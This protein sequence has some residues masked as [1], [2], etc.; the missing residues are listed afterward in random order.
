MGR[1]VW[2][3]DR[4]R[5]PCGLLPATV[6][7]DLEVHSLRSYFIRRGDHTEPIRFEVDRIRNGRSFS[8]RRV[9][10]RQAVGAILNL[11]ASFQRPEPSIDLQTDHDGLPV[12]PTPSRWSSQTVDAV[13]RSPLR[14]AD[15]VAAIPR[16]RCRSHAGVDE[17]Q[18][19]TRRR[20]A[21][22]ALLAGVPLRRPARP[23][24]C[25]RRPRSA[26][27]GRFVASLDHTHVVPSPGAR[28]QWHLH[29]FTLPQLRRR[30]R[31]GDR[32]RVRAPMACT[33]PRWRRKC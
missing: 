18:R 15:V 2:R 30:A 29:D 8:T 21:A 32:P 7:A 6:D 27:E 25:R 16:R 5:R 24:R 22:A 1:I 20:S 28:R 23:T 14:A 33:S 26:D 11:E 9:I 31:L 10:A 3:P 4:L 19:A 17:G 12:F 13:V